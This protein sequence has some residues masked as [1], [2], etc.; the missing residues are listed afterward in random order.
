MSVYPINRI[1]C[2]AHSWAQKARR[3]AKHY[4]YQPSTQ[5]TGYQ[6]LKRVMI[7]CETFSSFSSSPN[8]AISWHPIGIAVSAA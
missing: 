6:D 7:A 8:P 1:I 3:P 2:Q 4:L 5:D